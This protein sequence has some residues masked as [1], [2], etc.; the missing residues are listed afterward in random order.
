[1]RDYGIKLDSVGAA[2]QRVANIPAGGATIDAYFDRDSNRVT[3]HFVDGLDVD[4]IRHAIGAELGER[5]IA[6]VHI[7]AEIG[8]GVLVT[9]PAQTFVDYMQGEVPGLKR[10]LG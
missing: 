1:M 4:E 6:N 10:K 7:R 3:L 2:A 9:M 5:N 8:N